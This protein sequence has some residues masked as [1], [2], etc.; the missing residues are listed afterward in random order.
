MNTVLI[1]ILLGIVNLV[2]TCSVI[3][4]P[5]LA[6]RTGLKCLACHVN[7]TGG[8]KRTDYGVIY[9]KTTLSSEQL[10][11]KQATFDGFYQIIFL[12]VVILG[13]TLMPL[14]YSNKL[15]LQ[16]LTYSVLHSILKQ[17]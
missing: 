7:P 10:I 5:Y 2:L 16:N 6:A 13:L 12:S 11:T 15:I 8:G 1:I 9:S 14:K 3:A 17:H 4:E